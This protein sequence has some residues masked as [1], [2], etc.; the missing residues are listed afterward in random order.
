MGIN[1]IA[2]KLIESLDFPAGFAVCEFGNQRFKG[3]GTAQ[4]FYWGLGAKQYVSMDINGRGTRKVDLNF[5]LLAAERF[6]LVTDFGTGE[7]IF[8]Q[9]RLWRNRHELTQ[10]GGIMALVVPTQGYRSH[11]FYRF[12][13]ELIDAISTAN[14]YEVLFFEKNH[15]DKGVLLSAALRK[16]AEAWVNPIQ[17]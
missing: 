13:S 1:A 5:P 8:D 12:N 10:I 11:G 2:Q 14:S 15:T 6:D 3:P 16:T 17:C 7:H 9:G 4:E